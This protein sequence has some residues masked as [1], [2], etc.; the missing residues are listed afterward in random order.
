ML[1]VRYQTVPVA[2]GGGISALP[3]GVA[4]T[5]APAIRKPSARTPNLSDTP[6]PR[7][8]EQRGGAST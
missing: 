4:R 2:T 7:A 5:Q 1:F 3:M 8:R 6:S